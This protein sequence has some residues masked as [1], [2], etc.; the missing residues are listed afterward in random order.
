M[1]T[2]EMLKVLNAIVHA[3]RSVGATYLSQ[4]LAVPQATVG[5]WLKD[6]ED[7]GYLEKIS[8]RGR[9]LTSDGFEFY[10]KE[11]QSIQRK[12]TMEKFVGLIENASKV[13]L[14]EIIEIRKNLEC[15]AV[16]LTCRQITDEQLAALEALML[17]YAVEVRHG[18]SASE[19]DLE[20]HL[21]I[22][23]YSGNDSLYK[24]LRVLLTTDD[25]YNKFYSVSKDLENRSLC[26]QQHDEIISAIKKHDVEEAKEKM[27]IH[28]D[29][30][31][32]D[33]EQY[34]A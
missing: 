32:G 23:R 12:S 8:N 13:T 22:A 21:S 20:L 6:L 2:E 5:R 17:S 33:I 31:K 14:L 26:I 7:V 28:L 3:K 25:A 19:L 34:Y 9:L 18:G 27:R 16:E 4:E 1:Q 30:V 11:K 24:I 10:E 29:K 15:L